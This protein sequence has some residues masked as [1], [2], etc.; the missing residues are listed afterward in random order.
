MNLSV[1]RT[2]GR[3]K[4]RR[5]RVHVWLRKRN[6]QRRKAEV[7]KMLEYPR[8]RQKGE[9][10]E[11]WHQIRN[12]SKIKRRKQIKKICSEW[13]RIN[14]LPT[15]LE[16]G[17]L[18]HYETYK[19]YFISCRTYKWNKFFSFLTVMQSVQNRNCLKIES[20]N[21]SLRLIN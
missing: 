15:N 4:G 3:C 13:R 6:P 12:E 16:E 5:E 7:M 17:K 14:V 8:N 1:R 9:S 20:V 19:K 11:K 10:K 21:V 2:P 18:I